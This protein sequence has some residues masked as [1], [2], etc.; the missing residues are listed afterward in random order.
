MR[1]SEM[2]RHVWI[3]WNQARYLYPIH[4]VYRSWIVER[5]VERVLDAQA[6][7]DDA[8]NELGLH[9]LHDYRD[10]L[11][12]TERLRFTFWWQHV[13]NHGFDGD[14]PMKH[15]HKTKPKVAAK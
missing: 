1:Y 6:H 9:L 7:H 10:R 15:L 5:T 13:M 4:P 14:N 3:L 11:N 12:P 2:S 8:A